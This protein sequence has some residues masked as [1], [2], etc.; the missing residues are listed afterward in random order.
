MLCG[1][2]L[3]CMCVRVFVCVCVL[4]HAEKMWR[5][6]R[7]WIQ[8]R[9]RVYIQNV[10]VYASTAGTYFSTCARGAGTHK[11]VLNGHTGRKEE[12]VT[13]NSAHQDLP[14]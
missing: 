4:R 13:V 11:D 6:T 12:A 5:K 9:L 2:C 3:V 1:V 14:T 10:P 8:E 7:V